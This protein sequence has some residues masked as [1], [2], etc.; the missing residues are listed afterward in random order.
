M[1][2]LT[3]ATLD[4]VILIAYVVGSRLIFGWY[5]ARKR[6]QGDAEA[7]FLGG[8]NIHWALIGLSF[9]VSNMSGS[10]FVGLP[11]S[12]YLSGIAVYH[13]EWL[14]VVILIVFITF[15]LP[16]YLGAKVFTAPQFLE[17]RYDHRAKLIFSCFLLLANIFIDAAAALY[18][19][20][21]VMQVLFPEVPLW[22]TV[23]VAALIAGGYIFFGGLDAVVL[24]D[25]VQAL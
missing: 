15:I 21:M 13:Y 25:T 9:Y 5:I 24:N 11:G 10:T 4:I 23:A 2:T 17:K 7:Y 6:R 16:F 12:G 14:P 18:A 3:V 22:Q 20:A 8:R 1:P 19:G